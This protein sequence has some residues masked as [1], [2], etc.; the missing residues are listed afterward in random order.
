MNDN[1]NNTSEVIKKGVEGYVYIVSSK[2]I[3]VN[4][5]IQHLDNETGELCV[6]IKVGAAKD[7]D[8]RMGTLD[9][10]VP[11]DFVLHMRIK[12]PS[13]YELESA[14][15]KRLK[16]YQYPNTEFFAC[17]LTE[18]KK[19]LREALNDLIREKRWSRDACI[20]ETKFA[21]FGR[22]GAKMKS[23]REELFGGK[24]E[25]KC[26][27][28]G[29]EA[30]GV[31]KGEG[32]FVI[33]KGSKIS[34]VPAPKFESSKPIGYYKLWEVIQQDGRVD[35]DGNVVTD[36]EC[37][38][39]AMAASVVLASSRNGNKEWVEITSDKRKGRSLGEFFGR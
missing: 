13:M 22:S 4:K 17:E 29:I 8:K 1:I 35:K 21:Q 37:D 28:K 38:S 19:R 39:R 16:E 12:S 25:F 7:T 2:A 3:K 24:I 34:L 6:P 23:L 20:E 36:I 5:D 18:A 11:I 15:H 30:Y 26:A 33:K 32:C 10:A 9:S 14:C 27:Q 31:F